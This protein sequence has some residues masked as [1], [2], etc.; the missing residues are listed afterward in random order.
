MLRWYQLGDGYGVLRDAIE[1]PRMARESV[2]AAEGVGYV[3][4]INHVR[5]RV[6]KVKVAARS[7]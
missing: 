4:N 6:A 7:G 1:V 5:R 2:N 3:L